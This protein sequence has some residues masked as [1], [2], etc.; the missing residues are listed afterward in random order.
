MS[1]PLYGD[2]PTPLLTSEQRYAQYMEDARR[3]ARRGKIARQ[4]VTTAF[5]FAFWVM[6]VIV[7]L[8]TVATVY[9]FN[10]F[11]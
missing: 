10:N 7:F 11:R 2:I 3:A 6:T 1:R 8:V 5:R 4:M 9:Q